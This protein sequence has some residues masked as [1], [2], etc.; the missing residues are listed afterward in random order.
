[1]GTWFVHPANG[2]DAEAEAEQAFQRDKEAWNYLIAR[3][4]DVLIEPEKTLQEDHIAAAPHLGFY[5]WKREAMVYRL[6]GT[7]PK[8]QVLIVGAVGAVNVGQLVSEAQRRDL[9]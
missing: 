7:P 9:L 5:R 1:M 3:L 6:V 2:I 8:P 4:S